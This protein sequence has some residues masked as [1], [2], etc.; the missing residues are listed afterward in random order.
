[1]SAEEQ[2]NEHALEPSVGHR[3]HTASPA[4]RPAFALQRAAVL[5]DD[6]PTIGRFALKPGRMYPYSM[7]RPLSQC[8]R[9]K[10]AS[11]ESETQPYQRHEQ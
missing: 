6:N 1:M 7:G 2:G 3:A 4:K 10:S 11:D 5:S 9:D 8:D